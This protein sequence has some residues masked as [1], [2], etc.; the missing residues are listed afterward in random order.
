MLALALVLSMVVSPAQVEVHYMPLGTELALPSKERV[1]YFTFDEYKLLLKLDGDLWDTTKRLDIYKDLDLKYRGIVDQKDVIIKTL[2][3][4]RLVLTE[5][6]KRSDENWQAAEKRYIDA[7]GG[8]VWPYVVGAVGA[9]VG[10]V[11]ATLYLS[12]LAHR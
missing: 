11:G 3:D 10:I 2:Q 12:T 9:V 4:D 1:R 8:P 6:L 7:A 5:Q